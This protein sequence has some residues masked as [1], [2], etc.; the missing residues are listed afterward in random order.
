VDLRDPNDTDSM[1][2]KLLD[3]GLAE[4]LTP[5]VRTARLAPP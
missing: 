4:E 3:C 2:I 5:E 1:C